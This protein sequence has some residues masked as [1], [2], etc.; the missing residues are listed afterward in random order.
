MKIQEISA[1][2][3]EVEIINSIKHRYPELRQKSK[4]PTFALS[5]GGTPATLIKTLGF[6]PAEAMQLYKRYHE[7]YKESDK[8]V[9]DHLDKAETTG[10]VTC[11]FGL[12][13]R[14]HRMKKSVM[15][16]YHTPKEAAAERRT[17]GN[18]L[19]Q[20]WCMLTSRAGAE[21]NSKVR[22][23]RHRLDI[24]PIAQI[25]DAQY[26]LVKNTSAAVIWANTHLLEAIEW[27]EDPVIA[28]DDV[29]LKGELSLFYPDW[30]KE[31]V[32]PNQLTPEILKT[33][34]SNYLTQL[35]TREVQ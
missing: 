6:P 1:K 31:L 15:G 28:D 7:L 4:G 35:R 12:R 3:A 34:I 11:A 27:Q 23:S 19:G 33:M 18:A 8:W 16:V 13:V 24:L 25:H 9:N 30:S 29:K 32:L 5:Y 22:Q 21:F 14:T 26:F 2:Q 20:S 10:Y 17:A